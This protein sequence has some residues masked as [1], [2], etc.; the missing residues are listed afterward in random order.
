MVS[1]YPRLSLQRT[2]TAMQQVPNVPYV[3]C[4]KG[5]LK[6]RTGQLTSSRYCFIPVGFVSEN[7][8]NYHLEDGQKRRYLGRYPENYYGVG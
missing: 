7:E 4:L 6:T 3:L 1:V 8:I 2:E 5:S